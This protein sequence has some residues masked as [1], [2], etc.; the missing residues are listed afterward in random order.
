MHDK[1]LSSF[2]FAKYINV[3]TIK[4][5]RKRVCKHCLGVFTSKLLSYPNGISKNQQIRMGIKNLLTY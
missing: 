2:F 1:F 5:Q 4:V 3:Y